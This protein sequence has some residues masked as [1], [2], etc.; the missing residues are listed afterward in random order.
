MTSIGE[1]QT[2]NNNCGVA[3]IKKYFEKNSQIELILV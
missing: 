2:E 1:L 3:K